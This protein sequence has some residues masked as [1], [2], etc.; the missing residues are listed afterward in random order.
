MKTMNGEA[1]NPHAKRPPSDLE[2][3]LYVDGELEDDRLEEVR[4]AIERDD[5]LR[6]KVAALGLSSAIVRETALARDLDLTDAIMSKI[7]ADAGSSRDAR[8]VSPEVTPPERP[9]AE[10][11]PLLRKTPGAPKT[12]PSNDN[13]RGIFALAAVAVAAAAALMVWGRMDTGVPRPQSA[14]VAMVEATEAAPPAPAPAPEP[15]EQAA[16][17]EGDAEVGVE[18]A[19]VD[20]GSRIG[21]IFYVPTEAATS[22]HT[23]TVVW[24]SDDPA[25]GEQ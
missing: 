10:V 8:D 11:K 23:T 24:L 4:H 5:G 17:Q 6:K 16:A 21:T 20:F 25:G 15:H 13:A 1:R 12:G 9:M 19:A 3:M 2:L 18:V 7:A 22:N 14:P